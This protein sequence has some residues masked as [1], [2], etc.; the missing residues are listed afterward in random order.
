MTTYHSNYSAKVSSIDYSE[1]EKGKS[2]ILSINCKL[3]EYL[4]PIYR[5]PDYNNRWN[6]LQN[7]NVA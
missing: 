5:K 3:L 4:L 1:A 7:Y 6:I 2:K